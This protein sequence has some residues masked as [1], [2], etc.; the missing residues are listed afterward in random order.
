MPT[1]ANDWMTSF[2]L[3]VEEVE[4]KLRRALIGAV[5]TD[6]M[7]DAVSEALLYAWHNWS[8][9]STMERPVGYLFR[10]GQSKVRS[11]RQ[12]VIAVRPSEMPEVEPGLHDA[13]LRLPRQ[14]RVAVWLS[15][16]CRW[17]HAEVGE[18]LGVSTSTVATHVSRALVRLRSELG[19]VSD[20]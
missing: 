18:A 2:E 4:P 5:G 1:A 19:V 15:Y 14:Q 17:S 12:P 11:R 3:F 20:V 7:P 6:R 10:V 9:I 13:M 8:R 16:G